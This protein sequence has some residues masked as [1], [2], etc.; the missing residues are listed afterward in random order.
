MAIQGVHLIRGVCAALVVLAASQSAVPLAAQTPVD[1][2]AIRPLLLN[3]FESQRLQGQPYGE[4]KMVATD[5]G[6]SYYA[7]LD[8]A[9][10][11]TI[12]GED[13][14]SSLTEQQRTEW[15]DH[16][17]TYALPDGTYSDTFG[18]NQLHANGMTI[19]GL[20]ALGGQQLY[21]ATSVYAPFNEPAE[22]AGYLS[23]SINWTNQWG[24]SHKFWGGLD[25]YSHSSL[26]TPE[27]TSA[28]FD[29]LDSNVDSSTGWWRIGQQPADNINGLGG[30]AHIWPIYEQSGHAFP[31]PDRVIDRILGMQVSSG[32]F[33]GNNS[34]YMDLDALYGLKY[35]RS[36]DPSYRT[37]EIDQAVLK[38]GLWLNGDIN[39]FLAGTPT[40][41]ETLSRVGSFGLLNQLAPTLFPDSTGAHWTDIFTDPKL[42]Q[43][44][45]VET[46]S[47]GGAPVGQDQASFY[48]ATI[49]ASGPRGYWRM[50][51]TGGVAA[52]EAT[53]NAS[54]QGIYVGLG[55]GAGAGNL[56]QPGPRPASGFPG[57]SADNRAVHLNGSTSYVSVPDTADLDITGAL[58]MEAWIKLDSIPTGNGGILGKYLGSGNQRSYL[59]YVN[60]Q[61]AG[62]GALGMVISPNGTFTNAADLVDNV[63]L[64]TGEWLYVVGTYQPNQAMRLYVNGVL[65]GQR[66][67]GIP[68]QI[69]SSTADFWAGLQ[70]DSSIGN[71][72][73]GL[74]DEVAI[75][76]RALS[77][78]EI[79]AHFAAG[80][81]EPVPGDVNFDGVVNIFDVNVVSAHWN[82]AGPAGDANSDGVVDIFDINLISSHWTAGGSAAVPEPASFLLAAMT[83]C[84]CLCLWRSRRRASENRA[85]GGAR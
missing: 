47:V 56:A 74:I 66:T 4:Y 19:G 78:A 20:G 69:Y 64:P 43:T 34:G 46:F 21:P 77:A 48:S 58:T 10:A 11:R 76:A 82:E 2:A 40:L 55:T 8:V 3:K 17:H 50:G 16:L 63:P 61:G 31:F 53:G 27:W 41:H 28:V 38:Y 1:L 18:H 80:L 6:P 30:G 79:A 23:N 81:A 68:S 24:E 7:S 67:S 59:L 9:L 22:V 37:T 57:L 49:L 15:I 62:D 25:M 26:A 42:Y 72:L 12:M 35:M 32:R 73:P 65:V 54:L 71:H 52:A 70:F 84:G 85:S 13:L 75:Y 33:G 44:A 45:A 29:W 60:G 36:L 5:A 14:Q 83:G 39:S 51:Q